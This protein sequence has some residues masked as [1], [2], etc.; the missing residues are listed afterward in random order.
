MRRVGRLGRVG[1]IRVY[2]VINVHE[3]ICG[4]P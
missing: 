1:S 3:V 4:I 2:V